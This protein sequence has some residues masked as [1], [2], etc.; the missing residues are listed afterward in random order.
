VYGRLSRLLL[1]GAVTA[2]LALIVGC[3]EKKTALDTAAPPPSNPNAQP[4]VSPTKGRP[5]APPTM[6]GGPQS[7]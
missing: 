2:S 1:L 3:G 5:M 6:G 7:K 4:E